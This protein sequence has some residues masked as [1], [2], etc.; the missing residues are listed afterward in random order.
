MPTPRQ[1]DKEIALAG[2]LEL[3]LAKNCRNL[4]KSKKI[5]R[6]R[7]I[8]H[9]DATNVWDK[10]LETY[11]KRSVKVHRAKNAWMM[12]HGSYF[13]NNFLFLSSTKANMLKRVL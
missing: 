6:S 8:S 3:V 9:E 11:Y 10:F 1:D 12:K 5:E 7:N 4:Y 13:K 2:R